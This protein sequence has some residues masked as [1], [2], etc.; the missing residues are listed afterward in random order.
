VSLKKFTTF[1]VFLFFAISVA[2]FSPSET[3]AQIAVP[4]MEVPGSTLLTST[5]AIQASSGLTAVHTF[6]TSYNTARLS[7]KETGLGI[8]SGGTPLTGAE[9]AVQGGITGDSIGVQT[10]KL[11]MRQFTNSIVDWINNGFE[12][13]PAF[14]TDPENFFLGVADRA[15]GNF[16]EQLQVGTPFGTT[17]KG[18]LCKPFAL[19]VRL[20]LNLNYNRRFRDEIGCTLTDV[21]NNLENFGNDFSQGG[22]GQWFAMTQNSQ[23]H[24]DGAF[25]KAQGALEISVAGAQ[26]APLKDSDWGNGFLSF[27]KCEDPNE[28]TGECDR[29]GPA[30][31]PGTVVENQLSDA[32]GSD[33]R[34]WELAD[35]FDEIIGALLNQLMKQVMSQGLFS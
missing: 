14:I 8:Y 10:I 6:D 2:T 29:Y 5:L 13:G 32:L 24:R 3:N 12:G 1:F 25:L 18:F 15:A 19:D 20:A 7:A 21:G 16:L 34:Q 28:Q 27:R 4:V 9:L 23:N 33:L 31:T 22:W 11:V 17:T 35:E 26:F 30:R